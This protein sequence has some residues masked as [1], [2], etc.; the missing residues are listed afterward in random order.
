MKNT[1]VR[2]RIV[3]GFS[4][5]ILL[6]AALCAFAWMEL[7]GI[8]GQVDAL[9]T[10]SLPGLSVAGRLNTA[11]AESYASLEQCLFASDAATVA[12]CVATSRGK[13]AEV[14]ELAAS[15][16]RTIQTQADRDLYESIKAAIPPYV[17][18]GEQTLALYA[19]ANTRSRTQAVFLSQV[20]P[21]WRQLQAAIEAEV[22]S[23]KTNADLA[24]GRI[25]DAVS[26]ATT[27]LLLSL[28]AGLL[29]AGTAGYFLVKAVNSPL[30]LLVKA[31]EPMRS[32]DFSRKGDLPVAAEF[33]IL[34]GGL[35]AMAQSLSALIRRV[36]TSVLQVNTSATEIAATAQEQLTTANEVAATT[37][38]IGATSKEISTT[39]K[40]LVQTVKSIAD[41]A[42]TTAN[43]AGSGH[44]GLTRMK[45]TMQQIAD[46][47][48]NINSRLSTLSDKTTNIG[49]VV[50]TIT[51]VADQTNLLSL[52]A[53]IEAE[54]A[55]DY[56]RGFGV[57]ATEIRRL[58]DQTA[59]ATSDIEQMV[60]EMQ[61][62]V[63]AGVMGMD[64]FS[65]EVRQGVQVVQQVSE[66]LSQIIQHVQALAPNF[67]IVSEGIQSQSIGALQISDSLSQLTEVARQT[68]ESQRQSNSAIESLHEAARV[69]QDGV[70]RF[71][72]NT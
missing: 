28:I 16:E 60:K 44:A 39:S 32:G 58:A 12:Q 10:D 4:S 25:V 36:Q 69:L 7:H 46:A 67:T 11:S 22:K 54:K 38:E 42:A 18:A 71:V 21:A 49:M 1:T 14:R 41:V 30:A 50:T 15:Y 65:E 20:T 40:E 17:A 23:N 55:G 53:A 2:S 6:M 45:S 61:S 68:V 31:M 35:D 13:V 9:N 29:L 64:R 62:A 66:E 70:A 51:K 19:D 37:S 5:V 24:G 27:G 56:G 47:S 33:G 57:V 59:A 48:T 43:L 52:N 72:L 26:R 3:L 8:A 34:A 63:A